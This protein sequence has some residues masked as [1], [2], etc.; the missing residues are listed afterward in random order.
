MQR[1]V[2]METPISATELKITVKEPANNIFI[3]GKEK[4]TKQTS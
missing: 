4:K 1:S 3:I 2:T